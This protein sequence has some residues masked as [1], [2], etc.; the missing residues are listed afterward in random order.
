MTER[1]LDKGRMGKVVKTYLMLIA[2]AAR[3][4]TV[5]YRTVG[6]ATGVASINVSRDLLNPLY[7]RF[8]KV[9]HHPDLTTIVVN[10]TTGQPGKGHENYPERERVYLYNWTDYAPPTVAELNAMPEG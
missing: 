6:D 3:R 7:H 2:A 8:L 1:L 9:N 4:E 5:T 10:A